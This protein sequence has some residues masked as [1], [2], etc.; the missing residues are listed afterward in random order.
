MLTEP[1][2]PGERGNDTWVSVRTRSLNVRCLPPMKSLMPLTLALTAYQSGRYAAWVTMALLIVLL[3][4]RFLRR[5]RASDAVAALVVAVLL[6]GAL[7]RAGGGSDVDT[8]AAG[9]GGGSAP[10]SSAYGTNM[11]AGFMD[12]C[13]ENMSGEVDCRCL[14]SELTSQPSYSTPQGFAAMAEELEATKEI[15]SAYMAAVVTCGT[16]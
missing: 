15:P 6:V 9:A 11:R 5:R 8:A 10:W 7:V 12:G 4:R 3:V 1:F 2:L 13:R 16:T 14:F